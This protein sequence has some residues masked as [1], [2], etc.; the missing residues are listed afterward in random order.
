MRSSPVVK[1]LAIA[2]PLL[3]TTILWGMSKLAD[4]T[5]MLALSPALAIA[6][7]GGLYAVVLMAI[8]LLITTRS[9]L[10]EGIYGGLDKSFRLHRRLG[11]IALALIVAHLVALIPETRKLITLIVPFTASWWKTVGSIAVWL[12]TFVGVLAFW[13]RLPYQTWVSIH[14]WMGIPFLLAAVHA[15]AATS[16]ILGYEP[17]RTW[18]LLWAV[19]GG[20]A[21]IYRTFIYGAAG[22]RFDYVVDDV[23]DRGN[24]TW[25]LLLRPTTTRMN[26]EPGK[27][28]F[29]SV[30]NSPGL[31]DEQHPFSFSSSPVRRE[32]RFSYKAVGDYTTALGRVAKGSQVEVYGPFG[33]FTLHQLGE[34][35][36]LVWIAGGIGITPF[37][38]MLAFEA[39]N[40]DFRKIW[41]FYAV[42]SEDEAVY[43]A[44]IQQQVSSADSYIDYVKW[45]SSERGTISADAIIE[46]TG[47]IDDYAIMICGPT[48]MART[49]KKQFVSRGFHPSR[50]MYEDFSFR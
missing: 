31:P 1:I 27:F 19:A 45:V 18:M 2:L 37:L 48:A 16:D 28:A 15:F 3:V 20:V 26:Y 25:D 46:T 33:Q 39:T 4:E 6:Q 30:K 17:L 32:L 41:L 43:D 40:D 24:A 42:K 36:R 34:F 9:T 44:E 29:I 8:G 38:S 23:T 47:P 12:F 14:K 11:E 35:R 50:I 7:V 49:L 5:A 13:K 22:P 21:W 10:I